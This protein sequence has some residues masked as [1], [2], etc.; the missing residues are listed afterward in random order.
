MVAKIIW[1]KGIQHSNRNVLREGERK[2]SAGVA[3]AK[4]TVFIV[5]G[6]WH[7]QACSFSQVLESFL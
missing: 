3:K 4:N 7:G 6:S 5:N 2:C 1:E